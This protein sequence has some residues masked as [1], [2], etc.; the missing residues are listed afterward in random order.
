M[1]EF[2]LRVGVN[3]T[4]DVHNFPLILEPERKLQEKNTSQGQ[5]W[6]YI[7]ILC[8]MILFMK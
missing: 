4:N 6:F 1:N 3:V 7:M 2:I 5:I 8:D